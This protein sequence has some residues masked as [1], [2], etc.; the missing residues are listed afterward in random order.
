[1][2]TELYVEELTNLSYNLVFIIYK[3]LNSYKEDSVMLVSF[4]IYVLLEVIEIIICMVYLLFTF[5]RRNETW[6]K[7]LR[8]GLVSTMLLINLFQIP[9]EVKKDKSC[10]ISIGLVILWFYN[11]L[12]I[13]FQLGENE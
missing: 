9:M 1:M 7:K 10:I 4:D 11:A 12:A 8:L 13:V 2:N 5:Y 3:I 6:N